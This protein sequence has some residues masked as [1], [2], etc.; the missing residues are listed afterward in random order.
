MTRE[1]VSLHSVIKQLEAET[2]KPDS[3]VQKA[4]KSKHKELETLIQNI[5]QVLKHLDGLITKH[6][7]LG[8]E[9]RKKRDVIRFSAEGLEDIRSKIILHTSA[10][11]LFLGTLSAASLGRI[12][13]KLDEIVEE[14]RNGQRG[15]AAI[16]VSDDEDDPAAVKQWRALQKELVEDGFDKQ[17]IEDHKAW[18]KAE[19]R[20]RVAKRPDGAAKGH[21]SATDYTS[22]TTYTPMNY[23]NNTKIAQQ[24]GAFDP[25]F[26]RFANPWVSSG[27]PIDSNDSYALSSMLANTYISKPDSPAPQ[28]TLST[29]RTQEFDDDYGFPS[30]KLRRSPSL[31]SINS[32]HSE[33]AE[34]DADGNMTKKTT[35]IVTTKY[36]SVSGSASND[37]LLSEGENYSYVRTDLPP[38]P[39]SM[40]G[41][42]SSKISSSVQKKHKCKVCDK[43]FTRPSSLQT[44]M[45]SHTGERPFACEVEGCGRH[46]SVVSNLRRHR[47]AHKGEGRDHPTSDEDDC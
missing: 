43:R 29:A 25:N 34:Y 47:K 7:S 17:D 18:I 10:A 26:P 42:F 19:M 27:N 31:S 6:K 5:E 24:V 8:T 37:S 3:I 30:G 36:Y 22:A 15:T 45:Y 13:G 4:I 16:A 20:K 40:I 38:A 21:A 41:Q 33:L 44:H 39:Q 9:N 46:F 12:E 23:A 28:N 35:T 14:L 11:S 2:S 1:V 32:T